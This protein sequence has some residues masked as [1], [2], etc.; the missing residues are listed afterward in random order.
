MEITWNPIELKLKWTKQCVLATGSVDN[1]NDNLNIIFT[2][3]KTKWYASIVSLS[4]KDNQKL[5]K[6]LSKGDNKK[7]TN[8]YIYF[9]KSNFVGANRLFWFIQMKMST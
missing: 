3:K 5:S 7:T 6:L 2:I 1:T 4:A 9:L 8:E